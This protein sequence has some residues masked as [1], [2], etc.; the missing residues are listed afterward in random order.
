MVFKLIDVVVTPRMLSKE[1]HEMELN[2]LISMTVYEAKPIAVEYAI[3]EYG[4]TL[5]K[6][7]FEMAEWGKKHKRRIILEGGQTVSDC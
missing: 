7:L 6:V 3:T 4:M 2:E 1:L 5:E